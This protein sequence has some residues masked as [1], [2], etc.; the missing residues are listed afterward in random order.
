MLVLKNLI[1]VGRGTCGIT[2]LVERK[3]DKQQYCM[4]SV[5]VSN[6]SEFL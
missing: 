6:L 3:E 4:K 5:Q 1:I 2:Y